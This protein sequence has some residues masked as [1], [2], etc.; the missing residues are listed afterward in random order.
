[1]RGDGLSPDWAPSPKDYQ[2]ADFDEPRADYYWAITRARTRTDIKRLENTKVD[3]GF[4]DV[5]TRLASGGEQ[6]RDALRAVVDYTDDPEEKASVI[7]AARAWLY[8][9]DCL[10]NE[11]RGWLSTQAR[12]Y[13]AVAQTLRL[14][15]RAS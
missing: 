8:P 4:A 14:I 13:P 12:A 6:G 9:Y 2:P 5:V 10:P 7:E 3:Q 1:M 11:F 15:E